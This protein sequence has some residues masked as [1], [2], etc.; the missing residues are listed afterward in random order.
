MLGPGPATVLLFP[1]EY[2]SSFIPR[3]IVALHRAPVFSYLGIFGFSFGRDC[4]FVP[5]S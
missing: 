4:Y 5:C 2:K 3:K 1:V